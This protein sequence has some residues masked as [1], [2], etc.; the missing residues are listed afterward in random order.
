MLS[1]ANLL[2]LFLFV[3]LANVSL[4]ISIDFTPNA[5]SD[6]SNSEKSLF[7]SAANFWTSII[8]GYQDGVDR[9]WTLTVDSFSEAAANGSVRLGSATASGFA[10]SQFVA[11]S[12]YPHGRFI[13][14]TGGYASFNTHNNAGNLSET[15]IIHE[16]GHALGIGL[17]WEANEVYNDGDPSNNFSYLVNGGYY[18]RYLFGGTPGQYMGA[19][20]LNAYRNEFDPNALFIPVE[21]DGSS[22]TV[23]GHWNEVADNPS[24]ENLAGFDNDPG[25]DVPAPIVT[26]GPNS[27]KSFDDELMT[28]IMSGTPFLSETTKESLKDI[29]FTIPEPRTYVLVLGCLALIAGIRRKSADLRSKLE[30]PSL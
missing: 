25:D 21:L 8:S 28:G 19:A 22:G 9:D 7:Q 3:S 1:R 2:P 29:G 30:Q 12:N 16:I 20:G 13:Y 11:N 23:H 26:S 6:Y 17:V 15:V 14:T 10:I 27:G 24:L 18:E 4:N 5:D